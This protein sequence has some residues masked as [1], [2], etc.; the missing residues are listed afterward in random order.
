M[1]LQNL[2]AELRTQ[3]SS[4]SQRESEGAQQLL[5]LRQ[6]V[7]RLQESQKNFKDTISALER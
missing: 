4:L 5:D 1:E 6:E 3:N 7:I 2:N